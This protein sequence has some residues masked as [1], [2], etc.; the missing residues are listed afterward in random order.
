MQLSVLHYKKVN[1]IAEPCNLQYY[2]DRTH[3]VP[4]QRP[5][6]K[7]KETHKGFKLE[8]LEA[9]VGALPSVIM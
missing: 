1:E 4:E 3:N 8:T 7:W 6:R 9:V 5:V 2:K